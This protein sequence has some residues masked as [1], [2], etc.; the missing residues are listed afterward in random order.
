MR[1]D[2]SLVNLS[3]IYEKI[4]IH[5]IH[6]AFL[7]LYVAGSHSASVCCVQFKYFFVR[8]GYRKQKKSSREVFAATPKI[9]FAI[10]A[11]YSTKS[12]ERVV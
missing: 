1:K 12:S 2:C 11:R 6:T 5:T 7:E 9:D 10:A 3:H 8:A 4:Y